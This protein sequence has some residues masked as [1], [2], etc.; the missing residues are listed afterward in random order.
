MIQGLKI[1]YARVSSLE[2]SLV[3][4]LEALEAEA[5][6]KVFSEKRSGTSTRDRT[7]L[8]RCLQF[9]R[10]GDVLV[11]TRLDRLARSVQDLWQIV[12]MLAKKGVGFRCLQQPMDTTSPEGR[13]MFTMLG[14][15]AEF[16][17][18]L[19]RVRQMEGVAK[20]KAAGTYRGTVRK[21]DPAKI[22]HMRDVQKLTAY[23]I[24]KDL[25]AAPCTIYRTVKGGWGPSPIKRKTA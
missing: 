19:K 9:V 11:V 8:E 23:E 13:L 5:C 3:L 6:H 15:F 22:I 4:Q 20:A 10:E 2:Q 21:F 16:E 24:A 12:D 14:A 18:D 1:G 25:G 7:E 17:V